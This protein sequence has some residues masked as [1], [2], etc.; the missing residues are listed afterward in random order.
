MR[1][2]IDRDLL[3][4]KDNMYI[5]D[6]EGNQITL[7]ATLVPKSKNENEFGHINPSL[8]FDRKGNQLP[9]FKEALLKA[10][11]EVGLMDRSHP[12]RSELQAVK[13]HLNDMRTIVFNG[14][15]DPIK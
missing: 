13:D 10:F 8:S 12:T 15:S 5:F 3:R 7:V 2:V 4:R 9:E 6:D 1:I 11:G 14:K